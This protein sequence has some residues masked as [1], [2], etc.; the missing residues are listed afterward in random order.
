VGTSIFQVYLGVARPIEALGLD[1]HE[2]MLN[3]DDDVEAHYQRGF[4]FERPGHML[5]G[6][7]NTAIPAISP[8]GTSAVT[9]TAMVHGDP[10]AALRPEQYFDHK[11]RVA[12]QMLGWAEEIAPGLRDAVEVVEVGTPLTMTRYAGHLGGAIYGYESSTT[13]HTLLRP[14]P[15]SPV[16]G[17]FYVG[18]WTNPGGGYWPAISSGQMIGEI[19]A[20]RMKGEDG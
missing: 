6:C 8:P 18:A 1:H 10:W 3:E 9:L 12:D 13:S 16:P 7:P 4:T 19:M 5:I 2:V 17:L 14:S 15:V 11:H 20:S